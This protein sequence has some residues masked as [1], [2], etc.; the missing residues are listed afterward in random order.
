MGDIGEPCNTGDTVGNGFR[1]IRT[2]RIHP[3]K[4]NLEQNDNREYE[5][6]KPQII[7]DLTKSEIKE[8]I[9]IPLLELLLVKKRDGSTLDYRAIQ[10]IG[11]NLAKVGIELIETSNQ[12][13]SLSE[14]SRNEL[15]NRITEILEEILLRC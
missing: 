9:S 2:E 11:I 12:E 15:L 7:D 3:K 10:Q 8:Q 13:I 1:F 14:A 4:E 6:I 5:E